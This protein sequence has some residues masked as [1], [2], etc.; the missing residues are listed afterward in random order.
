MRGKAV[1]SPPDLAGES[2]LRRALRRGAFLPSV[3]AGFHGVPRPLLASTIHSYIWPTAAQI[4]QD[5]ADGK[6]SNWLEQLNSLYVKMGLLP[7]P[8]FDPAP[9]LGQ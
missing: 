8:Y 2:L 9:V 5:Y 6:M 3:A 7:Q 4:H 1:S